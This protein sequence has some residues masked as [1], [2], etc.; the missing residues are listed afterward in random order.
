MY[1][2]MARLL[3]WLQADEAGAAMLDRVRDLLLDER[4]VPAAGAVLSRLRDHAVV[5]YP[6]D[7]DRDPSAPTH[8]TAEDLTL[9]AAMA[10]CLPRAVRSMQSAGVPDDII[11]ATLRDFAIW[12]RV[13]RD[14]TGRLGIGETDWN[15]LSLTGNILRI[16]RLQYESI[17]F[18]DPYYV[19][20]HQASGRLAILAAFGLQVRPDG[21]L[22][23][24]NGVRTD[25]G[26]TTTLTAEATTVIGY[27]VDTTQGTIQ[28]EQVNLDQREYDLLMAP[29]L[30]TTSVHIPEDGSLS[31]EAVGAS[32]AEAVQF[33]SRL[34]RRTSIWFCESWL[35]D[36][37][38][39]RLES[40]DGNICRFM[41]RFAKF[42]VFSARPMIV[43]RVFGWGADNLATA[44]LP[45]RTSLQ[46][47]LKRCLLSGGEMFDVGGVIAVQ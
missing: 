17:T 26:F 31:P 23:G 15:L 25:A 37:N 9:A 19:Y 22:Q 3:Q 10:Y 33:L 27:P 43:E 47:N 30:P 46:R 16:G 24:T 38:L 41:R 29:G 21:R 12:A 1:E 13:Y 44:D 5:F 45:E 20:R 28:A 35:L 36:P 14:K 11:E 2:P 39:E 18:L 8:T 6:S 42:P 7:T 40:P 34:H 32:F 4:N